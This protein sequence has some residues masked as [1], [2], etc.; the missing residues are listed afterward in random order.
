MFLVGDIGGTNTR[1]AL[2][3]SNQK[4]I[5]EKRFLSSN[6][7][8]LIEAINDFLKNE[9]VKIKAASFGIAGP[10][11]NG[12]CQ[13]TNIP[14]IIDSNEI[15]TH[16]NIKNVY[17]LNDLQANAYGIEVLKE[18]EFYVINEGIKDQKGNRCLLAAGTGLGE[19]GLFFDGK[20]HIPFACE[21]GHCDFAARN[22][23]EIEIFKFL[24]KK[25]SHVS[26]ERILSGPGIYNLYSFLYE[27][28]LEQSPSEF[29]KEI[30]NSKEPQIAITK[31]AISSEMKIC[32]RT[33]EIFV[34]I[35]GA[36]AGNF[37]LKTFALNGVYIGG[38]I[39]P[40]ILEKLKEG[41]FFKSFID[42]GRFSSLLESIPIKVILND[43]AAL[44]GAA[45]YASINNN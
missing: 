24:E 40:K 11:R 3:E 38:G 33:I 7:N 1:L 29:H 14:W 2:F 34:S 20:K 35:Y 26:Y 12:K 31:K 44:L 27:S 32:E 42:K 15:R 21:G 18:D 19:A 4:C 8:S 39:A 17:L 25:Y 37:A 5:K 30:Q 28:K 43:K 9:K 41:H 13:T 45:Y 16:L 10:I 22:E 6:Y 23:L 36:E